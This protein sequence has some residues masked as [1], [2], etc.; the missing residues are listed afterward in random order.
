M[1]G[2]STLDSCDSRDSKDFSPEKQ[3]P[4]RSLTLPIELLWRDSEPSSLFLNG[5]WSQ[6]RTSK[7]SRL[8]FV[9]SWLMQLDIFKK[10]QWEVVIIHYLREVFQRKEQH[11]P[12]KRKDVWLE[13]RQEGNR[14]TFVL[15][16]KAALTMLFQV[17]WECTSENIQM[18]H[19]LHILPE[20]RSG[21]WFT[22]PFLGN[23]A[24]KPLQTLQSWKKRLCCHWVP[25]LGPTL[26]SPVDCS[27]QDIPGKNTGVG[28]HFL[29]Q[30]LFLTQGSNPHLLQVSCMAGRF[31]TTE[32][33]G[34]P[35]YKA[36]CGGKH[37]ISMYIWLKILDITWK[38]EA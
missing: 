33:P 21:Q 16:G 18:A 6:P 5:E 11:L 31:F 3:R 25:Q 26:C 30:R 8:R 24:T 1:K 36:L 34:I 19:R 35:I 4:D 13:A 23:K 14:I 9:R 7:R 37:I 27:P 10:R 22:V 29:L 20:G 2:F 38:V 17:K 28:F 12:K 32:P 15:R